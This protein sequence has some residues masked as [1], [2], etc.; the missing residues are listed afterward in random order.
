M[1]DTDER[2]GHEHRLAG[3]E[4]QAALEAHATPERVEIRQGSAGRVEASEVSVRQGAIGF[5]RADRI[6]VA[7]G[8]VGAALGRRVHVRQGFSRLAAARDSISLEQS[9]ALT[10][11]ANRVDVGRQ[12]G[13]VF[14][15]ARNVHGNV[16][17]LFDWR[18]GLAFGLGAGLVAFVAGLLPRRR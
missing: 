9:G 1:T 10:V 7:M 4:A 16:R 2:A 8:A 18:A 13:V 15:F 11:V 6:D 14:L 12:S 3:A 17:T 5:V